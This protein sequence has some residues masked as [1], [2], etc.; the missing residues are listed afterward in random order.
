MLYGL[1][2]VDTNGRWALAE[3]ESSGT[4]PC[5]V[6]FVLSTTCFFSWHVDSQ[7]SRSNEPNDHGPKPLKLRTKVKRSFSW[8][9]CHGS[10]RPTNQFWYRLHLRWCWIRYISIL[11]CIYVHVWYVCVF[12]HV[13]G[14]KVN[15]RYIPWLL[16]ILFDWSKAL[17]CTQIQGFWLG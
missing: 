13:C 7:S 16:S 11:S 5:P 3:G 4:H 10:G 15:I 8:A 6:P 1:L 2:G 14:P 9:F 17:L 12:S